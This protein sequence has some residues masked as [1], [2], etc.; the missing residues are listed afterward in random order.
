[1]LCYR[2]QYD[3]GVLVPFSSSLVVIC[4]LYFSCLCVKLFCVDFFHVI[5]QDLS[6]TAHKLCSVFSSLCPLLPNVPLSF[7]PSL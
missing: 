6:I 3:T 4:V 1:M 5:L 7:L 2:L